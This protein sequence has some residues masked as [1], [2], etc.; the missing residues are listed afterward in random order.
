MERVA[1]LEP[2]KVQVKVQV[3]RE[4][5]NKMPPLIGYFPTGFDPLKHSSSTSYQ[6]Y[7]NTNS[8]QL[9]VKPADSPFEFVGRNY[10]AVEGLKNVLG[11]LDKDA[12]T[13]TLVPIAGNEVNCEEGN[14]FFFGNLLVVCFSDLF[15]MCT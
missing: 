10:S 7:R 15:V 2:E 6:V 3:V 8:L 9:V 14:T 11:I 5:P 4:N 12:Q 1:E 13:L